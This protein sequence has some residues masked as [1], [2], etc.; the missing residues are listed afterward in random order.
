M[1]MSA[2][3]EPRITAC[4]D[5]GPDQSSP[6]KPPISSPMKLTAKTEVLII[7]HAPLIRSGLAA[8]IGVN[9]RFAVCAQTDDAPTA[10]ELFV[11]HQP[12][13]VALGLRLRRGSGI[14]LIKD[15]RRLNRAA[16]L[17][18]LRHAKIHCRFNVRSER[19]RT[20]T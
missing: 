1:Q 2:L 8:L 16:R 4:R 17:L 14:D 20:D 7:H 3:T 19:E 10:R 6:T 5:W 13:L 15:V 18:V 9:D 12:R 11:Q